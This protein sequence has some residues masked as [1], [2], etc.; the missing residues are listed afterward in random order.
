MGGADNPTGPAFQQYS[1]PV[2]GQDYD[3]EYVRWY[4]HERDLVHP[5]LNIFSFTGLVLLAAAVGLGLGYLVWLLAGC[6]WSLT[7]TLWVAGTVTLLGNLR[8]LFIGLV[9]LYQHYMPE[10]IRRN[11]ILLPTCSEYCILALKKYG[12]IRGCWK[13]VHRLLHTC[14]GDDYHTDWP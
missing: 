10:G 4:V 9:K 3:E 5:R 7:A 2:Y 6:H 1:E 13:T 11:C 14:V 8:M 12:V